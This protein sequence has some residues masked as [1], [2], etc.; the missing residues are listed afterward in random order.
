[1]FCSIL[2]Y[3]ESFPTFRG[4]SFVSRNVA[5]GLVSLI[6]KLIKGQT[7]SSYECCQFIQPFV[8]TL[9][10]ICWVFDNANMTQQDYDLSKGFQITFQ[11]ITL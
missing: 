7:I 4:E 2:S 11:V 3:N 10:G 1:M 8:G 5:M 6:N 9:R